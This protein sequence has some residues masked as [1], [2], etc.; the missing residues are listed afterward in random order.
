MAEERARVV[1]ASGLM[2]E[3]PEACRYV[4]ASCRVGNHLICEAR[5]VVPCTCP[6][7]RDIYSIV[8]R[9]GDYVIVTY[10]SGEL[11]LRPGRLLW[12]EELGESVGLKPVPGRLLGRG[13]WVRDPDFLVG[14]GTVETGSVDA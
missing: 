8:W 6:C 2:G 4:G 11:E 13:E 5:T 1:G 7:H 12:A 10:A 9:K 14:T 3:R